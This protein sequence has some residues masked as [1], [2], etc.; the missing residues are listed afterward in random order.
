MKPENR[1]LRD[2]HVH[3]TYLVQCSY[4]DDCYHHVVCW[5]LGHGLLIGRP[6]SA[7]REYV[8]AMTLTDLRWLQRRRPRHPDERALVQAMI[9]AVAGTRRDVLDWNVQ[10]C[11]GCPGV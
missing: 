10:G 9:D 3:T 2:H 8:L 6:A 1:Y 11:P 5:D 4:R 7:V